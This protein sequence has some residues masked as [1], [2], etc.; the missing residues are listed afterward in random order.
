[1]PEFNSAN[2]NRGKVFQVHY[3]I[4]DHTGRLFNYGGLYYFKQS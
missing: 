1:M 3:Y 2:L 4:I